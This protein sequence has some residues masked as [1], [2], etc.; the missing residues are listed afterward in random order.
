MR[1]TTS[2]IF[3]IVMILLLIIVVQTGVFAKTAAITGPI[4]ETQ[5]RAWTGSAWTAVTQGWLRAPA[6]LTATVGGGYGSTGATISTAGVIQANGAITTDGAI[7]AASATIAA[8]TTVSEATAARI[9]TSADYGKLI[10]ISTAGV[11][12]VTLPANGAPAGSMIDFL[13][14]VENAGTVTISPA[15]ADT[16]YTPNSSD[17]DAVTFATGQRIGSYCR[18]ISD[19]TRW[20]AVNLG[21]T[22]MGVTD[23]D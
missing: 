8:K 12:A 10:I 5:L 7:T 19:G 15:T 21:T 20:I 16:L 13:I 22:T 23:T 6:L 4:K 14:T 2:R 18:V 9:C 17:S 1:F 11:C 3:A